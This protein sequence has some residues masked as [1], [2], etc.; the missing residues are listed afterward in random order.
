MEKKILV[1]I[2]RFREISKLPLLSESPPPF[3][4]DDLIAKGVTRIKSLDIIIKKLGYEGK[5]LTDDEIDNLA[6]ELRAGGL[7]DDMVEGIKKAFKENTNLKSSLTHSS[8]DFVKALKSASKNGDAIS[9]VKMV[10]ELSYQKI[11]QITK[12]LVTKFLNDPENFYSKYLTNMDNSISENLQKI[13]DS[14]E[15]LYNIDEMY[16]IFDGF[17]NKRLSSLMEKGSIDAEFAETMLQECK[18]K[19]RGSSK[20]KDLL[21]KFKSEGRAS[22]TT[23]KRTTSVSKFDNT[24][25]L[26]DEWKSVKTWKVVDNNGKPI[27]RPSGVV[28]DIGGAETLFDDLPTSSADDATETVD[29]I[30]NKD[31]FERFGA[32][33]MDKEF[34]ASFQRLIKYA[35][36]LDSPNLK[37]IINGIKSGKKIKWK[38]QSEKD[39]VLGELKSQLPDSDYEIIM[40]R[41]DNPKPVLNVG[42]LGTFFWTTIEPLIKT[43][44]ESMMGGEYFKRILFKPKK[45]ADEYFNEFKSSLESKI[46]TVK[47]G[48]TEG[49]VKALKD[50]FVRL[51]SK[52]TE[53]DMDYAKLWGKLDNYVRKGLDAESLLSW[54]KITKQLMSES[55]SNWMWVSWEKIIKD[56]NLIQRAKIGMEESTRKGDVVL[57]IMEESALDVGE[58]WVKRNIKKYGPNL[59]SLFFTGRWK[60]PKEMQEFLISKGYAGRT[61]GKLWDWSAGGE[62]FIYRELWKYVVIPILWGA[63]DTV[64]QEIKEAGT[65]LELDKLTWYQNLLRQIGNEITGKD[66]ETVMEVLGS[67]IKSTLKLGTLQRE[68]PEWYS[69]LRP[70][71][72]GL[73][74]SP[75]SSVSID[76]F[77]TFVSI[78]KTVEESEIDLLDNSVKRVEE[79]LKKKNNTDKVD[80]W[81]KRIN[82]SMT[83]LGLVSPGIAKNVTENMSVKWG[84]DPAIVDGIR[85]TIKAVNKE[86]T[87]IIDKWKGGWTEAT[88]IEKLNDSA[89]EDILVKSKDGTF[90]LVDTDEFKGGIATGNGIQYIGED[91]NTHPLNELKF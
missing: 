7:S 22:S 82:Q 53:E 77:D 63:M 57:N 17:I 29:D 37:R 6:N 85:K 76:I 52:I 70:F 1:E 11:L 43:L 91:G 15:V 45:T 67:I 35:D 13:Y 73:L 62:N 54:E 9:G 39:S 23:L 78:K 86:D 69:S 28:D 51:T 65:N 10:K 2:N 81:T 44:R 88:A 89:I 80:K 61:K 30:L 75:A 3:W 87:K 4:V 56:P 60:T 34:L 42:R 19:Y 40:K 49:D 5:I 58:K 59:T 68:Y 18:S 66:E 31:I 27:I 8:E 21:D 84:V 48:F 12:S 38:N 72:E 24:N 14:G 50:K 20:T 46:I 36:Q 26:G 47:N 79:S 55:D 16:D 71:L 90:K 25:I 32:N 64:I 33:G 74:Q 41:L 83:R